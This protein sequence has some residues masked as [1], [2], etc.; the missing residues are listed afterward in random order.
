M[1]I[2]VTREQRDEQSLV[3]LLRVIQKY[4]NSAVALSLFRRPL[5]LSFKDLIHREDTLLQ[6][7]V[8]DRQLSR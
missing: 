4:Q 1:I 2:N 6:N 8:S 3:F 5:L 7:N